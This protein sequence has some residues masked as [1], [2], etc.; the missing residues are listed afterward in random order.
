MYEFAS[1]E[2]G[3]Q[4]PAERRQSLPWK[5][6]ESSTPTGAHGRGAERVLEGPSTTQEAGVLWQAGRS[7]GE[8][9]LLGEF[10]KERKDLVFSKGILVADVGTGWSQ[11]SG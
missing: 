6:R 7:P 8:K 1:L 11:K 5:N 4:S 3:V 2:W 9:G 10:S